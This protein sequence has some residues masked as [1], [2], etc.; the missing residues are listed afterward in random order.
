[1]GVLIDTSVVIAVQRRGGAPATLRLLGDEAR[2]LLSVVVVGELWYG[3][4]R[5]TDTRRRDLQVEYIDG[6][7]AATDVLPIE[8]D[9]ARTYAAL[10]RT[11]ELRGTPIGSN[12]L[13]IAAQALA[14]GHSVATLN[15]REFSR[16][17]GLRVIG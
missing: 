1:M 14:R 2:P 15:I 4:E 3:V 6:V 7:V 12:D 8:R 9:D 17:P 10:R 16:V 13:W 11:L 5:A